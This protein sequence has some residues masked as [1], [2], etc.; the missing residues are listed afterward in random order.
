[1]REKVLLPA[2]PC[3]AF[4]ATTCWHF[5]LKQSSIHMTKPNYTCLGKSRANIYTSA[6][7]SWNI[8]TDHE[9]NCWAPPS[10]S[11]SSDVHCT[12]PSKVMWLGSAHL[13]VPMLLCS[14]NVLV[15]YSFFP[16]DLTDTVTKHLQ[17]LSCGWLD[18][19]RH[20]FNIC[21]TW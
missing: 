2:P 6:F 8:Q 14:L 20:S 15:F 16:K 21:I 4:T 1:M 18:L 9:H 10:A 5:S 3:L 17:E 12:T 13:H 19:P 7:T 11:P